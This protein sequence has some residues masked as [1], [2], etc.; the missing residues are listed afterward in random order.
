M[1]NV[2]VAAT[3]MACTWDKPANVERA[4]QLVRAAAGGGAQIILLQ[5]LFE[6]PYFCIEQRGEHLQLAS[7]RDDNPLLQ[8]FQALA[9]ELA[10]VLPISWFERAGNNF[11]N[12][13]CMLDAD[14]SVLGYYRK[15]HIPNSIG[16]QEKTYFT[17][18]D[19]GFQVWDTRYARVGVAICWDQWFPEAARSMALRGAELLFY[20]TAIGTEPGEP[21]LDSSG[22][23]Q[24][25][26]QG[27]AAAN[28]VPIIASNRIGQ[29]LATGDE[30]LS[31]RFYGHSFIADYTGEIVQQ[32][33]D[34]SEAVLISDFDLDEAQQYRTQWGV[35][36]DRRPE[37]YGDLCMHTP[38]TC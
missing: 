15:S 30:S 9:K 32:A 1:R 11:F 12:T 25:T 4:I 20:P 22:H 29:E 18:G 8:R 19:T 27:H 34:S 35:F 16:Y 14:G 33:D 21:D 36:R 10:V 38:V 3:Q 24:R 37:L 13:V 17:P 31:M 7:E 5:E 23:W 28:V 2:S 26:M 6:T